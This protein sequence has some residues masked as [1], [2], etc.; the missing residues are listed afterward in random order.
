[1]LRTSRNHRQQ[2]LTSLQ[3]IPSSCAVL[4]CSTTCLHESMLPPALDLLMLRYLYYVMLQ[5]MR[6]IILQP[7]LFQEKLST[8]RLQGGLIAACTCSAYMQLS[9][10]H[11]AFAW[12]SIEYKM[13]FAY[14]S[15][16]RSY[17]IIRMS[18]Q[19][20]ILFRDEEESKPHPDTLHVYRLHVRC[21]HYITAG[22]SCHRS[23]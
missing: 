19:Y 6:S 18:L 5:D 8:C 15:S 22:R 16:C 3:T 20:P 13:Q 21:I 9:L 4:V 1:M 17:S 23:C 2:T 12:S 11:P 14:H 10:L 7:T